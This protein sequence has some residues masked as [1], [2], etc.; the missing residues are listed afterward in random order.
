L[1]D[2]CPNCRDH[3]ERH[4]SPNTFLSL[5]RTQLACDRGRGADC[6]PLHM[7]GSR[8]ALF[9]VRL[10]SHGY[11]LVAKGIEKGHRKYLV[12]ESKVYAHLRPIQGSC[13]PVSLGTV[14]LEL[15]YYYDAGIYFSMLFLSWGGRPLHQCLMPNNKACILS[16]ADRTLRE[17]HR[18]QVL[19]KDREP[20]NWL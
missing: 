14:D 1:D 17:L 5:I 3:Q 16:Q 15:P 10:T 18:Q 4:I 6:K 7:K 13:I 19:H 12:H 20:R 8:G 9:K 11:T 2:Q